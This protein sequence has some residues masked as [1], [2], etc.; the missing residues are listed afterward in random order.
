MDVNELRDR[1]D[2]WISLTDQIPTPSASDPLAATI[3]ERTDAEWDGAMLRNASK[4]AM[5]PGLKNTPAEKPL[6]E[7]IRLAKT[8]DRQHLPTIKQHLL[9]VQ[10]YM[11]EH[12]I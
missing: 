6:T 10:K 4:L 2:T 9:A 12:R 5:V 1:L 7:A 8:G 11:W 3:K